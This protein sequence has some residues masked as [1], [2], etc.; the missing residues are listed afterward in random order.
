MRRQRSAALS[1][2]DLSEGADV[3]VTDPNGMALAGPVLTT[4]EGTYAI[5]IANSALA[6]DIIIE[7]TGGQFTDEATGDTQ[8]PAGELSAYVTGGT[9]SSGSA[10]HLTPASTILRNIVAAGK[11]TAEAEAL[12]SQGFG[13]IPD[14]SVKPDDATNPPASSSESGR[15]AGLRAAAFSQLTQDLG[16]APDKQFELLEALA[17]D[18]IDNG[19]NGKDASGDIQ[20]PSG[21]FLPEDIQNRFERSLMRFRAG[22]KDKTGLTSDKIGVM[23]FGKIALTDS[24]RVEYIEMI[25]A[26]EGRT[27]FKIRV[28]DRS[29]GSPLKGLSMMLMPMMHMATHQH[30]TPIG[31]VTDNGDGTYTCEVYYLMASMM[32]NMPMGYWELKVMI[33]PDS[34]AAYFYPR[35]M[36]SMNGDTV[37]T[38]LRG[39]D[40]RIASMGMG[41]SRTYYL[42]N[43]GL[44]GSAGDYG[45]K[46]FI[47]TQ[48]SMM[49][50]PAVYPGE[51]LKDENG[52]TW[53]ITDMTVEVS[54]DG[55]VW[56]AAVNDGDGKW[57]VAGIT[58]LTKDTA[59]NIY[60]RLTINGEQ[61]TMDGFPLTGD[62]SNGYATFTVTPKN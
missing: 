53:D 3:K 15:L 34:E 16:L 37:R 28:S 42:F 48:E 47:A 56:T 13:F 35:V 45:F 21:S 24:Y 50:Y 2:P 1:L 55:A 33:G 12:F 19:L 61:K 27:Q 17:Q 22:D 36:M 51:S 31:N 60:V 46:L 32:N 25:P 14:L 52:N 49:N 57:S 11:T 54:T 59:G 26:M 58:G 9:L 38:T 4:A 39:I 30:S 62:E 18:L 10:V 6:G 5:K 44:T 8:V 29:T 7:S 40:D 41:I 43:N 23:P 20:M